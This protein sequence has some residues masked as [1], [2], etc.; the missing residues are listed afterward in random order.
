MR[1]GKSPKDAGLAALKR[2][3]ANTIE[4]RLLG[5][6]GKPNFNVTYYALNTKGEY[7]CV[8]LYESDKQPVRFAV[9]TE[10]GP[11]TV[12]AEALFP[13]SPED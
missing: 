2:I 8:S 3:V 1:Q 4:K 5:P 11:R 12:Q 9:C 13:G 6:G 10:E 7:A